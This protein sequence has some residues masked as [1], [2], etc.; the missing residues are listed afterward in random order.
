MRLTGRLKKE[1]ESIG[2]KEGKREAIRKAGMLLTDDE[3]D[4]ISG[5]LTRTVYTD[6]PFGAIV[7]GGPGKEYEQV[8]TLI[9]FTDVN[10][11]GCSYYN[12]MDGINWYEIDSPVYGWVGGDLI[13]LS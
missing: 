6:L 8:D 5:G 2:T 10:T 3:L 1:V 9:N 13:G 12:V 4:G 7:R 11:T